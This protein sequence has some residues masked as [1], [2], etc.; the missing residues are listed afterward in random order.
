MASSLRV[1]SSA[2]KVGVPEVKLGLF[3]G[4]GGTVRLSRLAGPAV[5]CDWV[6]GGQP[7][8]ADTALAVGV[9]NEV[10]APEALRSAALAL[11]RRAMAGEVDWAAQQ[12]R[13]RAPVPMPA[14]ERAPVFEA[15]L[16]KVAPLAARQQPAAQSAPCTLR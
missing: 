11:L 3:P 12:Q 6:G 14:A 10:V 16:A 2:A 5:A 9:V 7:Q 8:S 1:M 4:F 15:A 13:K